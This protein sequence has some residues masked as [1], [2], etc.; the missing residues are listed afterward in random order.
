MGGWELAVKAHASA[1]VRNH[2]RQCS[3]R[4]AGPSNR[5]QNRRRWQEAPSSRQ[6]QRASATICL[7]LRDGPE[8]LHEGVLHSLCQGMAA[9]G[10]PVLWA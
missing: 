9:T 7:R 6:D 5:R 2:R 3:T 10:M 1:G 8:V 4:T